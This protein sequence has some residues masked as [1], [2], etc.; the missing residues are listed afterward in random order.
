MVSKIFRAD[1]STLKMNLP[2]LMVAWLNF[3]DKYKN[4]SNQEA[5]FRG[6][7]L[8]SKYFNLFKQKLL[9]LLV[10]VSTL[11]YTWIFLSNFGEILKMISKSLECSILS[12]IHFNKSHTENSESIRMFKWIIIRNIRTFFCMNEM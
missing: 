4:C 6:R 2:R 10:T 5:F 11:T 12:P 7:F 1:D 8:K 9:I 3:L